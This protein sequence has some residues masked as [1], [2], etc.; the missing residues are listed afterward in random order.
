LSTTKTPA[1]R[2]E[3]NG[4]LRWVA[5]S[6]IKVNPRAQRDLRPGWAAQIAADFDPDRFTPPLISLRDGKHY[7]IDGQHRIEAMKVMGWHDQ[8][9]Q[10][11]V[12]ED[13]TEAQEA[14][15]FLWHNNRRSVGAFDK[16]QTAVVAERD[17]EVDINR[18]VLAN[19]LKVAQS[20]SGGIGAVGALR[21]VYGYGPATL[22]RTLRIIRDS[23]GDDG[24]KGEVIR[25]VGLM[26]ARYNGDLDDQT[27]VNKL[28]T[29][30]GGVGALMSKAHIYRKQL[31][32]PVPHC[33]AGAAVDILNAGRG[34]KKL[35]NWWS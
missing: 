17:V 33:V 35:P 4:H 1:T 6:D 29:A 23:Y 22:G 21:T 26:C 2:V 32:R 12:Y 15:L 19:G 5:I 11:W 34:G 13:M 18:I 25:G 16:F 9:V 14:D 3:R 28:S 24:F 8:Q 27:A 31:G 10:C 30:R 20:Q 7:V